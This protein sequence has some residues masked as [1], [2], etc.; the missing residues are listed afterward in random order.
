MKKI[1]TLDLIFVSL[2]SSI[3]YGLGFFIPSNMGVNYLFSLIICMVVGTIFDTFM[4]SILYSKYIQEKSYRRYTAFVVISL[5]FVLTWILSVKFLSHS[6]IGDVTIQ[7]LFVFGIP[8]ITF[9]ISII[10]ECIKRRRILKKYGS[11]EKGYFFNKEEIEDLYSFSSVNKEI[12]GEYDKSLS[13]KTKYGIYVGR[14]KGKQYFFNGIPY[15]KA[16]IGE[17]RFL[18]PQEPNYSNKVF[19][20]YYP[21]LSGV[22]PKSN[23][24]ILNNFPQSEDCLY[25]NVITS[26]I[27]NKGKKPVLVY[28]HGGDGRYGGSFNPLCSFENFSKKYDDVVIVNFNYRIGLFG[29][30]DFSDSIKDERLID[31]NSLTIKD[32]LLALKYIKENISL[33]DG[34]PNNITL[35]GD[36][37]GASYICVLATCKECTQLFKRAFIIAGSVYDMP[38]DNHYAKNLGNAIVKEFNAKT[39]DDL[40]AIK[41]E[42]LRQIYDKYYTSVEPTPFGSKYVVNNIFDLIEKGV[43]KNIEFIFGFGSGEYSGWEGMTKGDVETNKLIEDYYQNIKNIIAKD[44]KELFERIMNLYIDT[45]KDEYK[46]KYFLLS[47]FQFTVSVLSNASKFAKGGSNVHLF[48]W[49]KT[50]EVDKFKSNVISIVS[51]I[52]GNSKLALS[53]GYIIDDDNTEVFQALLHKYINGEKLEL[54]KNEI[55]G[56]DELVWKNYS[57]KEDNVLCVK[58]NAIENLHDVFSEKVKLIKELIS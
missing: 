48:Y 28:F 17:L 31:S 19:E 46:A 47:D 32:Q 29:V 57:D 41:T 55:R 2:F 49:D 58:D 22:Q 26:S 30:V 56:I 23:H 54:Y 13:I 50:N 38:V 8:V 36:S 53:M 3:G 16:P 25:L 27:S 7:Y 6:L 37:I 1:I 4:N 11:G 10:I 42:D 40:Q 33:F 51:T 43:A 14:K 24:N 34:D 35:M 12:T 39:L 9:L 18:S 5:V 15:A 21:G 44:K 52:L 20:A 45:Y